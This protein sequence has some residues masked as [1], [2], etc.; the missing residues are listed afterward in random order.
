MF[1][2]KF[3]QLNASKA[4]DIA[5][6]VSFPPIHDTFAITSPVAGLWTCH[7]NEIHLID[8][9]KTHTMEPI[10]LHNTASTKSFVFSEKF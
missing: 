10:H 3:L 5:S 4:E 2:H 1:S 8:V 6:F 9:I 7:K